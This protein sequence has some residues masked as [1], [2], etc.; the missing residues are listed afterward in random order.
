MKTI[1]SR[2]NPLVKRCQDVAAG[3]LSALMLLDGAHLVEEAVRARVQLT[4]VACSERGLALAGVRDTVERIR[5]TGT[6]TV[7]V[8]DEVLRAMSPVRSPS[9]IVALATRPARPLADLFAARGAPRSGP[10]ALR[11][12]PLV[13]VAADVQDP[14]NV[15][16]IV[17][18]AEAGGAS[19][20]VFTGAS[21][22]AFGWK[23]LRGSMGSA[24]RLPITTAAFDDLLSAARATGVRLLA[25]V[26][27]NGRPMFEADLRGPIAL[28]LGGE[29]PGLPA[30]LVE[31][32]DERVSIPMREPVESLNVAVAAALLVYEAGRQ[33][34]G[35]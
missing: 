17:R 3:K 28:L 16:A 18:A 29:G 5:A 1:T 12:S 10:A 13:V 35:G 4:A 8:T 34:A 9:G 30:N 23:A 14:G 6:E 2:H 32:A 26:P 24:L 15:G 25:T 11:V 31:A 21:A 7:C 20:A 33:R 22:D 27:R 19:G